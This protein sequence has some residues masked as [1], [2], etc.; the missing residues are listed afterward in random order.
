MMPM[1]REL[2]DSL[3]VYV[4]PDRPRGPPDA[5]EIKESACAAA[6]FDWNNTAF[7][8]LLTGC[9]VLVG[10]RGSGKSSLLSTFKGKR[11]M[12]RE[13]SGEEGRADPGA[14][15]PEREDPSWPC[16][17]SLLKPIRQVWS[18]S[19]EQYCVRRQSVPPVE[20]MARIWNTRIWLLAGRGLKENY[21]HLWDTLPQPARIT[22]C[23]RMSSSRRALMRR[24]AVG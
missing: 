14:A 10:R 7:A 3:R 11:F 6:L 12:H 2:A 13:L 19:L 18:D 23:R 4:R 16:P 8:E 17:M 22:S 15:Q 1:S 21:S 9:D 5:A 24:R 20:V